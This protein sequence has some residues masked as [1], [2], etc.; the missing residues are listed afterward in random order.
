MEGDVAEIRARFEEFKKRFDEE[1]RVGD[2][3]AGFRSWFEEDYMMRP[4]CRLVP[5][6][7]FIRCRGYG[8]VLTFRFVESS[9]NAA[10]TDACANLI[11]DADYYTLQGVVVTNLGM[12]MQ[13][14]THLLVRVHVAERCWKSV[15][16]VAWMSAVVRA[17]I[18][19]K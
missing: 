4:W 8:P 13:Y 14:G 18:N 2:A 9:H 5:V 16:Y 10:I 7:L 11:A 17:T 15:V 19:H 3:I 1:A 12:D 6:E